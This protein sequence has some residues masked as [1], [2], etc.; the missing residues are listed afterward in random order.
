MDKKL[1]ERQIQAKKYLDEFDIENVISEMLNSLLHEKDPHPYVYMIKY[2]ASLMTEEERKEFELEIPEPYP[3]AHPV[4]KFPY[5]SNSCKNLLSKYLTK[6]IFLTYRKV[7]TKFGNNINSIT[8]LTELLPEDKIG[9]ILSD[10]DCINA[11]SKLL[12]P[13]IDKV[14]NIKSKD[15]NEYQ[16]NY[17]YKI[18]N[19]D[20]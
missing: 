7:K 20:L 13:I 6:D 3:I 17:Y 10:C 2:L 5:F 9:C 15:L 19:S 1:P 11:Y 12:Q 8:K 18:L 14:H 4:V 16:L